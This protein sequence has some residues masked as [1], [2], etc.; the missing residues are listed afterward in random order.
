M[1]ISDFVAGLPKVEL[2]L[3]IEGSLEPSMMIALAKRNG[4]TLSYE[5]EE[6]VHAAYNFSNLQDFLD[7]YYQGMSVLITEQDFYD[8]TWAYLEVMAAQNVRHV[9]I[10]FDPQGHTSRGIAFETVIGG[11]T[12]ALDDGEKKLGITNRLIMCFLR[13]L[14]EED[15]FAT[16]EQALPY[17]ER[18]YGVGLDSSEV[19]F[20]PSLF[21]R[22]FARCHDEGFAL[23]A[24]AGEE[25]PAEYVRE[26]LDLLKIQR[27]DHGNKAMDDPDLVARIAKAGIA[28]TVCPLS[29]V[30]LKNVDSIEHH[31]IGRM[32]QAGLKATVNSDDPSYFG[33]YMNENYQAVMDG[34]GL[35]QQ[36][37][38]KLAQNAID[39][40]FATSERKTALAAELSRY[41]AG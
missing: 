26:S 19:G 41:L 9:E 8:L 36:Q 16:L 27:I 11:I 5:N 35:T 29:N 12:R 18:I 2:H 30:R 31:P 13:H 17:R 10:F 33:G 37:V 25:G 23:V 1:K 15:G 21:E 22:L 39:A 20:P 34:P 24:H 28:M 6:A 14:S 40:S 32:L 7:L 3:H 38:T 4:I